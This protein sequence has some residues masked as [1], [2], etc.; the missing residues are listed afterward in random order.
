M[1]I[2]ARVLPLLLV[3][4]TA[5]VAH[6]EP[7]IDPLEA[8]AAEIESIGV[9]GL[10]IMPYRRTYLLP[11]TYQLHPNEA[12]FSRQAAD[13]RP[14]NVEAKFQISLQFTLWRNIADS[15]AHL[16]AAYTQ[17]SLWQAY[18]GGASS[19]FRDTTYEPEAMLIVPCRFPVWGLTHRA[20]LAG[21][22]HQSNGQGAVGGLSRS[23]N[24]LY[25]RSILTRGPLVLD[26]RGWWRVPQTSDENPDISSYM[27]YGDL[28]ASY[29]WGRQAFSA[30]WR[31][32]LS[33]PRNRGAI[34]LGWS[35]PFVYGLR[36]Y[37]QYWNGYGETL[38]DYNHP[39]ERIGAGILLGEWL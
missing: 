5:A 30:M 23:W 28:A 10:A 31:N 4:L 37:V 15:R 16:Y 32:N 35:Y 7:G 38:V 9:K 11:A 27:G 13:A 25:V 33:T 39:T 14:Q 20:F 12:V 6:G 19:P 21:F 2:C 18:N 22:A 1:T 24:R 3:S 29:R 17:L 26:L 36:W 8:R 34:E